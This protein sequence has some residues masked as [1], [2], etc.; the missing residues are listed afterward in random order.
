MAEFSE[1]L[2]SIGSKIWDVA[3]SLA[4][5]VLA[6]NPVTAM[7]AL[8]AIGKAVGLT[9]DAKEVDI[10]AAI[11]PEMRL[12]ILVAE[13]DFKAVMRQKDNDELIARLADTQ[14]ARAMKSDGEKSTGKRDL[15]LYLLAWLMVV[16]FFVLMGVIMFVKVPEDSTGV[17]FMLFGALSSSFGA[18]IN[19]F[20]GSSQSS[21]DKT[22]LMGQ[23]RKEAFLK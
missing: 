13:Q 21:K 6:P 4:G 20:F 5:A 15:N 7:L 17:V 12:K 22:E 11:N 3:P 18:V 14:G 10:D 16:G 9:P 23:V 1:V 19:F 2:K 8:K